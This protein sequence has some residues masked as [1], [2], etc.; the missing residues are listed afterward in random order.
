M[1]H[2]KHLPRLEKILLY[3]DMFSRD[4]KS[5]RSG[6][7]QQQRLSGLPRKNAHEVPAAI[8]GSDTDDGSLQDSGASPIPRLLVVT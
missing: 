1:H 5:A 6:N 7:R 2:K 8:A 3:R 4:L